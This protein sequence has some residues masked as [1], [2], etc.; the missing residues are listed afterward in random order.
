MPN[1]LKSL[2]NLL[3]RSQ[4]QNPRAP[5]EE[6]SI[7][8]LPAFSTKTLFVNSGI[9][10]NVR[11]GPDVNSEKIGTI[12]YGAEV[13][14]LQEQSK[15]FK[16]KSS[17]LQGW[18][19]SVY[20]TEEKPA[21]QI[22]R[23]VKEDVS[24]EFPR[25]QKAVA[26]LANDANTVKLRKIIND[27]FGGGANGW[28]LQCTEYV[29]YK[30]RQMGIRISW[31]AE[32]PRHGGRWAGIFERNGLYKVL[33][34]PKAGCAM[35][36]TTGFKSDAMNET[37]HVA[38]VEQVLEDGSVKISEANWPQPGKYNERVVLVSEWRDKYKCRF[39]DFS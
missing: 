23:V 6:K 32:R 39:V 7:E 30:L 10:L 9:G 16:I 24:G 25:F 34:E 22:E 5:V 28:D 20:L 2:I 1:W 12:S 35:C 19:S 8:I 4:A 3:L 14:V 11:S 15:W 27:E 26:N 21:A 37:G 29:C 33:V 18:V 36:F 17:D 38:F 31:P 13:T